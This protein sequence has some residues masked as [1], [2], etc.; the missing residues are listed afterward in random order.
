MISTLVFRGT[1]SSSEVSS[2]LRRPA[3]SRIAFSN[4][5]TRSC[6]SKQFYIIYVFLVLFNVISNFNVT[7]LLVGLLVRMAQLSEWY[8][9]ELATFSFLGL[10][11]HRSLSNVFEDL[12]RVVGQ[13]LKLRIWNS[14]R[15]VFRSLLGF[16]RLL[17]LFLLASQPLCFCV[18]LL[19]LSPFQL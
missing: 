5:C 1:I 4:R 8:N 11:F 3:E 6:A 18:L 10:S 17:L 9:A 7:T 2:W 13:F 15:R 12:S 14:L 19:R 16:L